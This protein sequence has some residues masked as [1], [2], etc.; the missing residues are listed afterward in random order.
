M[1]YLISQMFFCLI[2]TF[3]CGLVLGYLLCKILCKCDKKDEVIST[4]KKPSSTSLT[5]AKSG[6]MADNSDTSTEAN[7]A[8]PSAANIATNTASAATSS[9]AAAPISSTDKDK[10]PNLTTLDSAVDLDSD[11]YTIETLEGIGPKTGKMFREYGI[12]TIGDYLRKLHSHEAREQAAKDLEIR[13]KPLHGW[14]SMSDLLRIQGMDHQYA[15]LAFASGIKTVGELAASNANELK[16]TMETTNKA[17]KQLI[18]PKVPSSDEVTNWVDV[19][20]HMQAVVS[21]A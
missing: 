16:N 5:E 17:G 12:T 20:K 2:I 11:S 1:S 7:N 10:T 6:L 19:A 4:K 14:A 18:A 21:V 15:E 9:V 8:T 3:V 13:V